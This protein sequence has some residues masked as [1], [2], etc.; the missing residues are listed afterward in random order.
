MP[1]YIP[2]MKIFGLVQRWLM[3][4]EFTK[5]FFHCQAGVRAAGRVHERGV[6]GDGGGD[7]RG[8][9]Q[10][11]HHA[12]VHHPPTQRVVS[13][14]NYLYVGYVVAVLKINIS[15]LQFDHVILIELVTSL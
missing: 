2:N 10:G 13:W 1:T 7:V 14:R 6:A 11:R 5:H 3:A 9:H 4:E 15:N 12:A 8:G